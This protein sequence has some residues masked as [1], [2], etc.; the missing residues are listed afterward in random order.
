MY[1]KY[2][3]KNYESVKKEALPTKKSE[4]LHFSRQVLGKFTLSTWRKNSKYSGNR[5]K[6]SYWL[7]PMRTSESAAKEEV[8]RIRT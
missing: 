6:I 3:K 5:L 8:K 7:P 1:V 2:T 4:Y